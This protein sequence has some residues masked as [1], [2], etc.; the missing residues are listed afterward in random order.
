M[1]SAPGSS[2]GPI[3][4]GISRVSLSIHASAF[5]YG[6]HSIV[7]AGPGGSGK[8][9][10]ARSIAPQQILADG[11]AELEFWRNEASVVGSHD[12]G[13]FPLAALLFTKVGSPARVEKIGPRHA[14]RLF[15]ESCLTLP[16]LSEQPEKRAGA[17]RAC[18]RLASLLPAAKIVNDLRSDLAPS[19]LEF[20]SEVAG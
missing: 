20:L 15:L 13:R 3:L 19:I 7:V 4:A 2:E 6:E 5:Q 10:I 11:F 14:A 12:C 8:T 1:L 17:A 9:H 16:L 18:W